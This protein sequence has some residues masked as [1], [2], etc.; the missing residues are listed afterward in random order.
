MKKIATFFHRLGPGIITGVADD[1]PS[2]TATCSQAGAG[3]GYNL[4]WIAF[5]A[6]PFQT[7]VQEACARIGAVTGKGLTAVVKS[8]YSRPLLYLVVS[9]AVIANTINIGADIGAMAAAAQLLIPV[10]FIL[11]SFL[12]AAVTIVL[13]VFIPYRRYSKILK[14]LTLSLLAYP[15]TLFIIRQP[16]LTLLKATFI[17]HLE[18]NLPFLFMITGLL[19]TIISP[20]MFFWQASEETEE[21]KEQHLKVGPVFIRHMRTDNF[22]GMLISQIGTWT[23]IAVAASVLFTHGI[24]N[25]QTAADAAAA[26]EPLVTTFPNSGL[27]AKVIFS[28]GII[29]LGLL[30]VPVLAGSAA[31]ALSETLGWKEGLN[32][33]FSAAR[34]FYL[35]IIFSTLI[36]LSL[37]FL[38]INPIK[39]L[40]L[41]AVIN[42]IIAGPLVFIIFQIAKNSSI[43][44]KYT[45]GSLSNFLVFSTFLLMSLTSLALLFS[46]YR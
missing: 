17:P 7:A 3:F 14:W 45:S 28:V 38:G 12:F 6:L 41:S 39:A 5:F 24:T 23:I 37:N 35:I 44:G 29:G 40:V 10:N 2:G 42:G 31:Y 1:D 15:V 22:L 34:G 11:L 19:G 25:I 21:Q 4:L 33:K 43:M 46:V 13:E 36:G 8:H 20:Y 30:A 9:L 32:R 16:W 27:W 18:F 26:L